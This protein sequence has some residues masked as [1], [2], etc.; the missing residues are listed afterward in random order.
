MIKYI[1]ANSNKLSSMK[2]IIEQAIKK[3]LKELK[4]PEVKFTVEHPENMAWGDYS[5]NV[6]IVINSNKVAPSQSKGATFKICAKLKA[7]ESMKK[8]A[9]EIK[10]AGAG[11]INISIQSE[12]LITLTNKLL[13]GNWEKPLKRSK[14]MVEFTDPNPFKEF[15]IGHLFSNIV[16]ESLARLFISQ[17][18]EVKR[19]CY[20]GDVG[21][22][23]AKAVW[24]MK[25]KNWATVIKKPLADRIKFMGQAYALGATAYEDSS[26]DGEAAKKEMEVL[27]QKIYEL[28]ESVKQL[29]ETGRAWSLEYFETLY[30]RLGTKFD[31]YF[32]EREAGEIGLE[33]VKEYLKKDVFVKSQGAVIFAGSKYGLHDR[34]FIN[35]LGLPTYE[36]KDLGLALAKFEKY[37]YDQSVIVTG[38]EIN[39]YFKVVLTALNKINPDLRRKTKHLGHGMVRLPEGKMSS[40]TGKVL[41]GEWLLDEA[42]QKIKTAFKSSEAVA[43]AVAVGAVKY[44]LLKS[45]I[46]QDVVFDF[47]KS[48]SFEGN[49]GPYLQY[50]HA[51]AKSV[52]AKAGKPEKGRTLFTDKVRPCHPEEEILLRTLYRYEE[53]VAAAAEELAPNQIAEF[54]YDLAQKFNSFYN[55][56]RVIGSGKAEPFRLW[57]TQATAEI[58]KQGL[59]LLGI[60]CP[61]KM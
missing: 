43:E 22:H 6:G 10:V 54:L 17:G 45:G 23:V 57:L 14:I 39:E 56:H 9:S 4:L 37:P 24:G 61:E 47:D 50:T 31:Y 53:V 41:T 27:N 19:A 7:E 36:A 55:K 2:Q 30:Q 25:K 46:G 49:S 29:Y 51:R 11:F 44:A 26:A 1:I 13:K 18:A 28:D 8:L 42:K 16:G 3:V 33:L 20:Q 15:H 21:M 59:E 48:I 52:L 58:I 34:V 35:Q 5:T 32:F 38:N 12:C 60:S 40:R